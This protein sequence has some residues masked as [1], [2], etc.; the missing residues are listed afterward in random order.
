MIIRFFYNS[1]KS[2]FAKIL[3]G[4]IILSFGLWGVGDIVRSYVSS[5]TAIQ[6]GKHKIPIDKLRYE[7]SQKKQNLRDKNGKSLTIEEFKN[8][9]ISKVILDDIIEQTVETETIRQIGIVVPKISLAQVIQSLP[10]FQTNGVFDERLYVNMLQQSG[11]SESRLLRQIRDSISR[12]QLFHPVISG[13]KM[14][15]FIRDVL[16][17]VYETNKTIWIAK[18]DIN[19]TKIN[20]NIDD[21]AL[22][23]YYQNS[24]DKYKK[25]ELRHIALMKTNYAKF[26]DEVKITEDEI[27]TYFND[28]Q[29]MFKSTETR[30]FERFDFN[31]KELAEATLEKLVKGGENSRSTAQSLLGIKKS[32]FPKYIAD[33]L[34]SLTVGKFSNVYSVG[35]KFYIYK[36]TK[37]NKPKEKKQS[38][39]INDVRNALLSEKL[40]SPEFYST[41]RDVKNRIEDA[42]ASGADIDKVANDYKS[43][44]IDIEDYDKQKDTERIKDIIPDD[45]THKEII[46]LVATLN[47]KQSSPVISSKENE[48]ISYVVYVRNIVKES[49]PP[50]EAIKDQITKDYIADLKNKETL[51]VLNDLIGESDN[52]VSQIKVF[53]GAKSYTVCKKDLLLD[54]DNNDWKKLQKDCPY[55]RVISDA[56]SVLKQ[57]KCKFYRLDADTYLVFGVEKFQSPKYASSTMRF[58]IKQFLDR[59]MNSD[60]YTIA[61]TET[62]KRQKIVIHKKIVDEA[63]RTSENSDGE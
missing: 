8:T 49:L 59:T 10:E 34:F 55:P 4:A 19:K 60:I 39:I 56:L 14:P 35:G 41:I 21:S 36:L 47:E 53:P 23:Q 45:E 32:N 7:Y 24:A 37:I 28:H 29:D 13:Y 43:E 62:K 15:S 17:S 58:L 50:I 33:D 52:A 38:E 12:N 40:N 48:N 9:D 31:T 6:V 18:I 44:L 22:K 1:S 3:F 11:M 42:L 63:I 5:R 16:G 51:S 26:V 2:I 20:D 25:P 61:Q 30:D 27:K 46:S 57:N 54:S